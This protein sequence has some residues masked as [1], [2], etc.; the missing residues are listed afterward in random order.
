[1]SATHEVSEQ[2]EAV[3]ISNASF[4]DIWQLYNH[5]KLCFNK[6]DRW[7]LIE[8]VGSLTLPGM[9]RLKMTCGDHM[10]GFFGGSRHLMEGKGAITTISIDPAWQGKGLGARLLAAGEAAL[11]TR[12]F[13]LSTRRSNLPAIHL[14]EKAGYKQTQVWEKYYFGEDALV[15]EKA[16]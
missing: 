6:L 3:Q 2:A 13:I 16:L 14:Y 10:I 8:L 9:V 4:K 15:F 1:M 7:P 5:E 12:V 11:G